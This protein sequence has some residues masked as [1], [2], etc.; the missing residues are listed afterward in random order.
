VIPARN[1]EGTL[2]RALESLLAQSG[3][4]FEAVVVENGGRPRAA[5]REK[6]AG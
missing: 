6:L 4:S 5:R 3:Q 2:A 1:A